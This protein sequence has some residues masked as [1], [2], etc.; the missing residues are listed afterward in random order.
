MENLAQT[1][2]Y[3]DD[4]ECSINISQSDDRGEI[5]LTRVYVDQIAKT[6]L[7]TAEQEIELAKDIEAGLYAEH[8]FIQ[9]AEDGVEIDPDIAPDYDLII[10][11]G[12]AAKRHMLEAN[13]RLVVSI[14]RRYTDTS[15]PQRDLIQEGNIG[16]MRAVE[17]FDYSK[18]YKFSTYATWWIRKAM[19][20]GVA[21][22]A[23]TVRLPYHLGRKVNTL[24][25]L[26]SETEAGTGKAMT[27]EEL[28]IASGLPVSTVKDYLEWST[29]SISLNTVIGESET[30]ELGDIIVDTDTESEIERQVEFQSMAQKLTDIMS[31]LTQDERSVLSLTYGLDDGIERNA[32]QIG[33][34]L[35][36]HQG[37]VSKIKKRAIEKLRANI[38]HE[39]RVFLD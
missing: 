4:T 11:Q 12:E 13:L 3:E 9:S 1:D 28:A 30:R 29:E 15:L 26:K 17:K 27:S 22:Q 38:S 7:L 18:G 6:A 2:L 10:R 21:E 32:T 8:L 24:R 14:A 34:L 31:L 36:L 39:M 16:L 33:K 23:R 25:K 20:L 19:A 5:D 37:T 35:G